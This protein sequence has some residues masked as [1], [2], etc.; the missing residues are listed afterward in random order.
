M[1][2]QPEA[3]QYDAGVYQLEQTDPVLAG[4]GGITNKPLLNLAN[5]TKYL[6]QRI[7]EILGVNKGYSVAGGTANA[8]TAIYTPA[9]TTV[10]DGM[11]LRFKG[12]AANT[13]PATFTPN[14]AT[15]A[16]QAIYGMDHAP[17]LG[18]EIVVNGECEVQFDAALNSGAGAWVLVRNSG[19]S[20]NGITA[21]ISDYTNRY[22]TT[23]FVL[24]QA[25][26]NLPQSMTAAG[27]V[28]TSASFSREDHVHPQVGVTPAL[29][30]NSLSLATTE[31]VQ[32]LAGNFQACQSITGSITLALAQSGMFFELAAGTYT[33][34]LPAPTT[35]NLRYTLYGAA[36]GVAATLATPS[37]S[38]YCAGVARSSMALGG[39]VVLDLISDGGNWVAFNA[40]P[41][42]SLSNSGYQKLPSGL[43]IQWAQ[44]AC[45]AG[46]TTTTAFPIAFPT[47]CLNVAGSG[48]QAAGNQ[49]AYAVVNGKTAANFTWNAFLA[50]GGSAPTL[51]AT[52]GAVQMWYIAIG[53]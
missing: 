4:L 53:Y 43:I 11:V 28:G 13:G 14:S 40:G 32:R 7:Q 26:S 2:N 25:S 33:V 51:A 39:F 48:Y 47:A 10:V 12:T 29:G 41:T 36:S 24:N 37:G 19:G 18:G 50:A 22:A 16:A 6:Y 52:G 17:L 9:I 20:R 21:A 30:D 15:I 8:I 42:V 35:K 46:A 1:A 45:A 23:K 38:I 49:Q 31:F 5:R 34:T 44:A 27:A 3:D